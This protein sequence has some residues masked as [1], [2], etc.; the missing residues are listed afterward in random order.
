MQYSYEHAQKIIFIFTYSN[1]HDRGSYRDG[2]LVS[3]PK[4]CAGTVGTQITVEDLFYNLKTRRL[5]LKNTSEEYHLILDVMSKY[6]V[7]YGGQGISFCCKKVRTIIQ[8]MKEQP[9]LI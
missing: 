1:K 2:K 8:C 7:H 9:K 4:P 6:A 5:A 3:V